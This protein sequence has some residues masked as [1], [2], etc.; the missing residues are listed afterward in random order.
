[1]EQEVSCRGRGLRL[2]RGDL[3]EGREGGK[4]GCSILLSMLPH[5]CFAGSG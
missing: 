1:M 2:R 4:R 5:S 3:E